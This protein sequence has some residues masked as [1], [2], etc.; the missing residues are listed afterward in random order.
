MD[1]YLQ[2]PPELLQLIVRQLDPVSLIALS[3]TSR[4]WRALISPIHHDFVQRLLVLELQPKHGGIVPLFTERDDAFSFTPPW[5]IERWKTIN[6]ACCG[7]MKLRGH[8]MFDNRAILGRRYRKPPPGS[9]EARKATLTDWEP[10]N[11]GARWRLIQK[12]AGEEEQRRQNWRDVAR[13]IYKPHGP[14]PHPFAQQ[15]PIHD[16]AYYRVLERLFAGTSRQNR[17]CIECRYQRGDWRKQPV[18]GG[19]I[20]RGNA[21]CPVV[22][23][24]QFPFPSLWERHFPG[25]PLPGPMPAPKAPRRWRVLREWVDSGND[26]YTLYAVRCPSCGK[27]QESSAFRQWTLWHRRFPDM[28]QPVHCLRLL[29]N[30]CHLNTY[31]DKGLLAKELNDGAILTINKERREM[32]SCL[33]RGWRLIHNDFYHPKGALSDLKYQ[34][35]RGEIFDGVT[36]ADCRVEV[37]MTSF[38]VTDL[39][40]YR[41]RFDRLREFINHELD[42]KTRAEILQSWLRV[43]FEEYELIEDMYCWLNYQEIAISSNPYYVFNYVMEKAPYYIDTIYGNY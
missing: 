11:H 22:V 40:L 43:W 2:L 7:C 34:A 27:W 41:L 38:D 9:V 5:T 17:R 21:K 31:K 35:V 3:Q 18:F 14:P 20:L 33:T 30:H 24:R 42:L 1:P 10:L 36:L 4:A 29:C 39:R 25:L 12:R 6:Y 15:P 28:G 19:Q 13:R 8:M 37:D 16:V 26:Y 32:F 23:S